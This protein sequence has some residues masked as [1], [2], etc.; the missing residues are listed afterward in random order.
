MYRCE[1]RHIELVN[2]R[3]GFIGN[4][5]KAKRSIERKLHPPAP[6]DDSPDF[7]EQWLWYEIEIVHRFY[8][9]SHDYGESHPCMG[10]RPSGT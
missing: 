6:S 9:V 2:S 4:P 5:Q 8:F 3:V 1:H 10:L 7:A